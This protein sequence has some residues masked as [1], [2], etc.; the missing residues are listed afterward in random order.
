[1]PFKSDKHRKAVM[2]MLH[3]RGAKQYTAVVGKP[4]DPP[5]NDEEIDF[6]AQPRNARRIAR[7]KLK[8]GYVKG[9]KVKDI[10]RSGGVGWIQSW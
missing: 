2:A 7:G 6:W 8:Q 10:S 1:M 3:K 9:L 4:N 5:S